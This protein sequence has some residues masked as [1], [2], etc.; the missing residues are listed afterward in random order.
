M[1]IIARCCQSR[2]SAFHGLDKPIYIPSDIESDVSDIDTSDADQDD[3]EPSDST[4]PSIDTLVKQQGYTSRRGT[5]WLLVRA[6]QESLG[7]IYLVSTR[8]GR[9]LE[10][11]IQRVGM[12]SVS[13]APHLRDK[14][15]KEKS[16]KKG[17]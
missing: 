16:R 1:A 5:L 12:Q 11:R 15:R 7:Y 17:Y 2:P 3:R 14:P 6:Q 4:L 8:D 13:I 10:G 9:F